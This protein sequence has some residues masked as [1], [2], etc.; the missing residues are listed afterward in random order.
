MII[1]LLLWVITLYGNGT[2]TVGLNTTI[3]GG[4][5]ITLAL[6]VQPQSYIMVTVNGSPWYYILNGSLI[7]VPIFGTANVSIT[8]VPHALMENNFIGINVGNSTVEITIPSDVLIANITLSLINMTMSNNE[9][10]II[11]KGPGGNSY[12]Q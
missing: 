12:I 3:T 7:T 6:P 8:Y 1:P 11:A 10:I 9:L 5:S 4:Q 2:A